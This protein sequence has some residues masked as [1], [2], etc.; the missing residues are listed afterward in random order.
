MP[1]NELPDAYGIAD[2]SFPPSFGR[3]MLYP[4]KQ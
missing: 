3:Q 2:R 1:E 4:F